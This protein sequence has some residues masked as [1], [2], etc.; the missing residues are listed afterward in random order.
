MQK[1]LTV[2]QMLARLL[3]V[4]QI[5]IGI[6]MWFGMATGMVALH[7]ALGS[8]F[9][10]VVW[11]IAGIA[12]FALPQRTLPFLT[13]VLGAM[14]LWM[15]MAQVTM[16]PGDMHWLVRVLHL[17]LGVATLGVVESLCA[18]TKRHWAAVH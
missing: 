8:M 17:L 6:A 18:K 7:T 5:L 14:V 10:L 15:G 4:V 13:L 12:L 16:L 11:I 9:V 1:S 2:L 3:G